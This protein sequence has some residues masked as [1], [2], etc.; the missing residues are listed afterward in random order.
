M[1]Y[2]KFLSFLIVLGLASCAPK[3]AKETTSDAKSTASGDFR[4]MAPKAGPARAIEIGKSTNFT[5]ANGLKVI[6]VENHKLPQISY[7]LTIDRDPILEKEKAGLSSIAGSL[8]ATGTTSK[9]KAEI[10]EAVDYIGASLSTNG[11][12]GFASSL[13]KHSDK[14]LALFSDVIL[15][16]SFPQNEFDK[17]KTQTLSG[18]QT[19]KDD[20]NA[21]S[22]NVSSALTYGTNHPYGEITNEIT[23]SN[24]NLKDCVDYYHANFKPGTA[25]LVIVGDITPEVAKSKAENYFGGWTAGKTTPQAYAFPKPVEKTEVDFVDKAGAVQ[26]VINIT[27]AVDMKPGAEDVIPARV[28]NTILGSGFSGRLFKNLREDKAYTYGA[29][30]S[31]EP[32]K[33]VG[34]F[35]ANA[36]VRNEVTDSAVTQFLIELNKMKTEPVT[37]KE[38]ELAKAFIAGG[39]ARGLESPQTVANFALNTMMYNLPADYYETYLQKLAAVSIDDVSRVAKKYI[40]PDM[41][42]IIVVGNKDE[43]MAKLTGFDKQDGKIQLYDIYANPKKDES[44]TVVDVDAKKLID[45]YLTAIG[46]SKLDAVTSL[47]QTYS[48]EIQGMSMTTRMVQTAGKFYMAMSMQGS[49]VMKQV[50]DGEKAIA[51]QM[52]QSAPLE[53]ED[54]ASMKEKANL[55][56]ERMYKTEGYTM[57]VKGIE[58]VN[59]KSCYKLV[60]TK[61]SGSKSTEFYDKETF[62]KVKEIN[63]ETSMGETSTTIVEYADYNAVDGITVP[64]TISISG[65]MP[66][67]LVMKAT[68]VKVN[69]PVDPMLFKI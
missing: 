12:G 51:E 6:V 5:L 68:S 59:G 52:G 63:V 62:L 13:T 30:S 27:Y 20:P 23:V 1:R 32:N 38:L 48:M 36:S 7:Q 42:R 43:V 58:D 66:M 26:S 18:L 21:I 55:F 15:K 39:F 4:S 10:D 16:P 40:T 2:I 8:L 44:S 41:A 61:P 31:L 69:T 45:A 53:G 3:V 11:T 35:S 67:P 50:Y 49:N 65:P 37:A 28:M 60:V 64:Y 34:Q 25:Y 29:Y 24:I 56:P 46:G 17:I 33:L 22:S 47:D 14:I 9:T 19:E 54:L 57:E